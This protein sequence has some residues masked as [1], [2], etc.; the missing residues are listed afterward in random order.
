MKKWI[1]LLTLTLATNSF[2]MAEKAKDGS[3]YKKR[4]HKMAQE[5]GLSSEQIDQ[6]KSLKKGSFKESKALRQNVKEAKKDFHAL[7]ESEGQGETFNSKA[8]AA[9]SKLQTSKNKLMENRFNESLQLRSILTNDQ[10]KKFNDL[11]KKHKGKFKKR[12]N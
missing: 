1:Y 3:K 7:M 2:A 4:M 9:F 10:L 12:K 5:L 6:L 8:R 11:R